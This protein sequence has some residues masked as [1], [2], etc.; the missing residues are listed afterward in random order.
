MDV[1]T[2][3]SLSMIAPRL[4]SIATK[5]LF[6]RCACDP[7]RLHY[8]RDPGH[9]SC[10]PPS[11]LG[12][13]VELLLHFFFSSCAQPRRGCRKYFLINFFSVHHAEPFNNVHLTASAGC[14][15]PLLPFLPKHSSANCSSPLLA[16]IVSLPAFF[17]YSERD[18]RPHQP[19][20]SFA[21]ARE[22]RATIFRYV[23]VP[24]FLPSLPSF[25]FLSLLSFFRLL[26]RLLFF[27]LFLLCS[28]FLFFFHVFSFFL[29]SSR[30][31][32]HSRS[33]FCLHCGCSSFDV[34]LTIFPSSSTAIPVLTS[35]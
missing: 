2:L 29:L 18:Q 20:Q 19:L 21:Q 10:K 26:F 24:P 4:L 9:V 32:S 30:H 11:L 34:C 3:S 33:S 12:L 5:T 16:P 25:L 23:Q 6:P 1:T 22:E 31:M 17:L 15:I 8:R 14:C 27:L 28:F 7:H 13:F 35:L